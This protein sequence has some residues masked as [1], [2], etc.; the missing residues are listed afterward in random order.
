MKASEVT[1]AGFYWYDDDGQWVIMEAIKSGSGC[2]FTFCGSEVASEAIELAGDFVGPLA[3][4][5]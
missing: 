5:A 2:Y 4:P 3:P 1:E